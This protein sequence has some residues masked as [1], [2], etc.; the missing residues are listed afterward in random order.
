MQQTLP[1]PDL[2][3]IRYTF[4]RSSAW[5]EKQ[6]SYARLHPDG[7]IDRARTT[8]TWNLRTGDVRAGSSRGRNQ[9]TVHLTFLSS[10][11]V[12]FEQ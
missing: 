6:R 11:S 9:G 7:N 5:P 2:I 12:A 3:L 1:I 10:Q 8:D 4:H